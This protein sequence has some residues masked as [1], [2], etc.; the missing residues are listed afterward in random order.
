ML[1]YTAINLRLL[2]NVLTM[3][4]IKGK[5]KFDNLGVNCGL[6]EDGERIIEVECSTA[7]INKFIKTWVRLENC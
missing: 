2:K 3:Y 7:E 4:P 1:G 5:G 6:S